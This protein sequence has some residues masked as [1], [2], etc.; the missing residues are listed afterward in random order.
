MDVQEQIISDLKNRVTE[1]TKQKEDY[2]RQTQA[3]F[4]QNVA[5]ME[6]G[7]SEVQHLITML[8]TQPTTPPNNDDQQKPAPTDNQVQP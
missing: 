4:S 7:I 1:L 2:M 5:A 8:T 3:E 6:G